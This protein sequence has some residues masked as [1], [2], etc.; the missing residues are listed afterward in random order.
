MINNIRKLNVFNYV[1]EEQLVA[2]SYH[3]TRDKHFRHKDITGATIMQ[4][5]FRNYPE[6]TEMLLGM[7]V[8]LSVETYEVDSTFRKRWEIIA[9]VTTDQKRQWD[10]YKFM[11]KLAGKNRELI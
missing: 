4:L 11:E 2:H 8:S 10:E 7:G 6:D 3:Y 1:Q 5:M 9:H